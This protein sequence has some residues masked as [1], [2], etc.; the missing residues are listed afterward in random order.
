[1]G[2]KRFCL[3]KSLRGKS[4]IMERLKE[5][6]NGL[7][8]EKYFSYHFRDFIALL[9]VIA[10][11]TGISMF[12]SSLNT[13]W[14]FVIG[15]VFMAFFITFIAF[16][17]RK[18]GMVFLAFLLATIFVRPLPDLTGLG[19]KAYAIM[20]ISGFIF[21]II[22]LI[23][24]METK[25]IPFDVISALSVSLALIPLWTGILLSFEIVKERFMEV[26]NLIF[27]DF[28]IAIIGSLLAFLLWFHFRI[29]KKVIEFKYGYNKWI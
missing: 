13:P 28:F 10:V 17:L 7:K 22:Y 3:I 6:L 29:N 12:F 18:F 1:M 8:E 19:G 20:M 21:E 27:L 23:T 24:Y 14:N 5:T 2:V 25:V 11:W 9:L 15:F 4:E 26:L 16:L